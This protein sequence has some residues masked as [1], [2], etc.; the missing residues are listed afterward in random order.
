[1]ASINSLFTLDSAKEITVVAYGKNG[2][3]LLEKQIKLPV[4]E[5]AINP[6]MTS[7]ASGYAYKFYRDGLYILENPVDTTYKFYARDYISS[8]TVAEKSALVIKI[9]NANAI[10][11]N[12]VLFVFNGKFGEF[13]SF[14]PSEPNSWP[15]DSTAMDLTGAV[16]FDVEDNAS[17]NVEDGAR[18]VK[19]S[20]VYPLSVTRVYLDL[21]QDV[22]ASKGLTFEF[23]SAPVASG[24]VT[25]G[26]DDSVT[27]TVGTMQY[28]TEY[29]V[30]VKETTGDED[31]ATFTFLLTE[32]EQIQ[33][34]QTSYGRQVGEDV[35]LDFFVID[36]RGNPMPGQEVFMRENTYITPAPEN[37]LI[38]VRESTTLTDSNGKASFTYTKSDPSNNA[39]QR[40][41]AYVVSKPTVR[42]DNVIVYWSR[43]P[44]GIVTVDEVAYQQL[45]NGTTR[46][47]TVTMKN[48]NGTP[49]TQNLLLVQFNAGAENANYNLYVRDLSKQATEANAWIKSSLG[50]PAN[51]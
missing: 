47:F 30:K 50:T 44:V 29:E 26:G 23:Q 27:L 17:Y 41:T 3:A 51:P 2:E 11:T 12:R 31:A 32:P 13:M 45:G 14:N 16:V 33:I 19:I 42:N 22:D 28:N 25:Y 20:N 34:A 15:E 4:V 35:T 43:N 9:V 37:A 48:A 7:R 10:N 46:D 8:M 24:N 38:P 1:V 49:K 36:D 39:G 5:K 18:S 21:N 40:V 6:V